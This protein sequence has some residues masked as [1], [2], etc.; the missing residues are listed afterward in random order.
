VIENKSYYPIVCWQNCSG[1][2][3]LHS[4]HSKSEVVPWPLRS[5]GTAK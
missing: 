5:W 3:V 1:L 4:Y 2:F